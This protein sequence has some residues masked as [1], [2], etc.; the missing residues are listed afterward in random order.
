AALRLEYVQALFAQPICK[1]DEVSMG[2]V[3]NTIT[4]LSNTI[5]SSVSDKLAILFQ[6]LSLLIAAYTIA[7]R[8]S[9]SLTLVVSAAIL[10]AVIA[11]III[12]PVM[13]KAQRSM[14]EADH[15][16]ASIAADAISSFRTVLSLGA[17]TSLMRK[18]SQW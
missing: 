17:E 2:T 12:L 8:F 14:D 4:A 7:F 5:R 11:F 3:T 15:K 10:F 9:W 6:S 1:L 13:V 18:Y 16:H